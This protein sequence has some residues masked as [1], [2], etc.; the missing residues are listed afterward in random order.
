MHLSEVLEKDRETVDHALQTVLLSIKNRTPSRLCDAMAYALLAPGKRLR[1]FLCL[2]IGRCLKIPEDRLLPVACAIEMVHCY[3]L[4]HDDLPAMD[5]AD[6]RRGRPSVHKEFD[7][8]TAILAGNA[9]QTLAF[10]TLASATVSEDGEIRCLLIRRLAEAIGAQGMMGGQI[11]DLQGET[12]SCSF[13]DIQQME[14][15]KTGALIGFSVTAPAYLKGADVRDIHHLDAFAELIGLAFQVTDDV[16]DIEQTPEILGKPA[17]SD[18][19]H[20]KSTFASLLGLEPAKSF[21]QELI[22]KA[23]NHLKDLSF[24]APLLEE[25]CHYILQRNR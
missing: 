16:L 8:A 21:A 9:L 15:L 1:A 12:C 4:I 10:E 25:T 14:V 24:P 23:R 6:L 7:E 22:Q 17:G 2:E 13:E 18:A 11:L 20:H 3:S 5:D 19:A